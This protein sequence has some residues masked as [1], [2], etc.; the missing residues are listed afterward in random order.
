MRFRFKYLALAVIGLYAVLLIP[1]PAPV[2]PPAGESRAFAWRQ[3]EHWSGLEAHFRATRASSC[4]SLSEQLTA[5]VKRGQKLLG[6]L[7][8]HNL[9][10]G[11]P[12]KR[13]SQ[14]WNLTEA[15][16][17]V[18]LYRLLY[19]SRAAV[20]EAMLQAPAGSLQALAHGEAEPAV[21]P[22][23]NI[24]GVTIHSGDI[25][26]SRGG[27]PTSALIARGNDYAGNF[28]HIALAHVD[29]KTHEAAIIEAHIERGVA[30]AT[31]EEYLQ[32][33]KLRVLVLRL[34]AD[35]PALA[36]DPML[37]HR[38]AVQALQAA[39]DRHIPYDFEMD[40]R[41]HARLFCSEVASAAYEKT[42]MHLWM[43]ISHIS[44]PGVRAWLSAFGVK[45][46]ETQEPADLEYDP[47]LRVVAEWRDPETLW[48]DHVDN[49]VID[50][51]LE[52]AEQGER[53]EYA[54]Y[55]LPLARIA[56]AYSALLNAF[57]KIGPIPEGMNAA[58][59]LRNDQ[60]TQTHLALKKIV[61]RA[62]EDFERQQGYR[63]PYWELLEIARAARRGQS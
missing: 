63:P 19:G 41:D 34:R 49:A 52:G 25:L 16:A 14:H 46:F 31:L 55:K 36:A 22:A 4:D 17:R 51:M 42:G 37:P 26:V 2:P 5:L 57:G 62:A 56:K 32:D 44:S 59:A 11:A 12:I 61:L 53:L 54:W 48:Q 47:Q 43:G 6:S 8:R 3:D 38:A 30:I 40:Y 13:Q 45:H 7:T 21:T 10:P 15:E 35:L 24:L 23:T 9:D 20:E 28:S 58:A 29:E 39:R 33:K 60:F 1:S 27:A 50:A 18:R